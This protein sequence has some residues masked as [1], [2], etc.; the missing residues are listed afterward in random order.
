M[1]RSGCWR[2]GGPRVRLRADDDRY[3]KE[4][5]K[6]AVVKESGTLLVSSTGATIN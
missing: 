1:A 6:T 2:D 3:E 5:K 4:T